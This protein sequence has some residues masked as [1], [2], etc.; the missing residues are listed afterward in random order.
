MKRDDG[1]FMNTVIGDCNI[2]NY[3]LGGIYKKMIELYTA[4]GTGLFRMIHR[5]LR[6][7][8]ARLIRS[9]VDLTTVVIRERDI[10]MQ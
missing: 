6:R 2:G 5:R 8:D 9:R 1:R 3:P 4:M 10:R 7:G